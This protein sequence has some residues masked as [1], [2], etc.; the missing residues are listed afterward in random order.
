MAG[1]ERAHITV[2]DPGERQHAIQ[3]PGIEMLPA[4]PRM[5]GLLRTEAEQASGMQI[6]I[7]FMNIGIGVMQNVVLL[8]P[9]DVTA[10][11]EI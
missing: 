1:N 6:G 5:P 11:Y 10:A 8:T 2:Q 3:R 4:M 9:P 7:T